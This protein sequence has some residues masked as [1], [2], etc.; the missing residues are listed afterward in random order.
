MFLYRSALK[1]GVNA[2]GTWL[3]H[4]YQ[5]WS[6][7]RSA[8]SGGPHAFP[9]LTYMV[10]SDSRCCWLVSVPLATALHVQGT[11][12]RGIAHSGVGLS[13]PVKGDDKVPVDEFDHVTGMEK[14]VLML[15]CS[16]WTCLPGCCTCQS[17]QRAPAV[18]VHS[19]ACEE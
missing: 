7:G 2:A 17:P 9:N 16:A 14:C 1:P 4:K 3:P 13:D 8:S 6:A 18:C 19:F 15:H 5:A 12:V 10:N 11:A